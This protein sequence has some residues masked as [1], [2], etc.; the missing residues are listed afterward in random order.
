M[1]TF[2]YVLINPAGK[3]QKGSIDAETREAAIG[4]LRKD[5][6]TVVSLE[7]ANALNKDLNISFLEAKPKPRDMAVFCRQFV[8]IVEAGVPVVSALEMLG[9]QTENKML[10]TAINDCKHSIE[11]GETLH[12]SMAQHPKVF[13]G[14]F[15]TM[16]EAGEASGSLDVSFERMAQQ[17]EKQAELKAA[18]KKATIYP[19][20]IAILTVA[21]AAL[22]LTFVVPTFKTM[23]DD[24]GTELP[25]LTKFVLALSDSLQSSWYIYLIVIAAIVVGIKL[26]KKSAAGVHLFAKMGL[27]IPLF[28]R[29]TTK[30]AAAQMSRTL[31]TLVASGLQLTDALEI[32]AGTLANIFFKEDVLAA[33]DQVMMGAPLA[34]Q[35]KAS[36]LWPPLVHHMISIG[37]ETGSLDTML[38][39]L[40]EYYEEEVKQETERVMAVLEPLVIVVLAL[41]VGGIVLSVILPMA[42]M[43]DSLNNL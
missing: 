40:A 38:D 6:G 2:T 43:Y 28:G 19:V 29:L 11:L 9:E 8:S 23:F 3:Q 17:F 10:A 1:A 27:K 13:P 18:I 41:I 30:T 7:E 36:G 37:E 24:L 26:F 14:I 5:G 15:V 25:G 22:L 42:S 31:S 4:E 20:I 33:R 39:K 12:S 32:T 34:G 21:A 35:F 16:V